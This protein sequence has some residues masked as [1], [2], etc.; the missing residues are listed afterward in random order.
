[1]FRRLE[2]RLDVLKPTLQ[3]IYNPDLN[4]SNLIQ[5]IDS[6]QVKLDQTSLFSLNRFSGIDK[7]ESGLRLNTGIEYNVADHGNFSYDFALGQIF[8]EAP[9]TQFSEDSGL[10]GIKSDILISG[11]INY[12]SLLTLRGQQLYDQSLKLKQAETTLDW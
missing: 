5:N 7:Q 9:S 2:R 1:M 6:Q 11:N 12:N 3:L 10:S 4:N 8:R